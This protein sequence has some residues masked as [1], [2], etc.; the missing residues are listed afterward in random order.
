[1]HGGGAV[2]GEGEGRGVVVVVLRVREG[3]VKG[4]NVFFLA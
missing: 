4:A 2:E 1:M 3:R